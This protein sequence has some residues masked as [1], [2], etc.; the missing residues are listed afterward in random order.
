MSVVSKLIKK[1]VNSL[2]D[3]Y[4]FKKNFFFQ[5]GFRYF[6]LSVDLLTDNCSLWI[7][8][9]LNIFCATRPLSLISRTFGMIWEHVFVTNIHLMEFLVRIPDSF[10]HFFQEE[11]ALTGS[12]ESPCRRCSI[13][14][15]VS[16]DFF[17][18]PHFL[19]YINDLSDDII[20]NIVRLVS[21]FFLGS[22]CFVWF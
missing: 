7:A 20:C 11:A 21:S 22:C 13:N 10:I 1:V 17:L 5:Y 18:G 19:L 14:Y 15:G 3:S 6:C 9:A 4:H 12:R 8:R 2:Q 16:Q